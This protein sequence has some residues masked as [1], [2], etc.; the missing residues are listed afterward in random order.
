MIPEL[1][2]TTHFSFLR[3]ASSPEELFAAAAAQVAGVTGRLEVPVELVSPDLVPG[4]AEIGARQAL[5]GEFLFRFGGLLDRTL[6]QSDF[7]LGYLSVLAWLRLDRLAAYGV[8]PEAAQRALRCVEKAYTP[9]D[10]WRRAGS[11]TAASLSWRSRLRLVHLAFNAG[12]VA[13]RGHRS[14]SADP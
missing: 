10:M 5:A 9:S 2:V 12:L 7:D 6:R 3:G 14:A 1:Q 13:A 11:S 4:V 8:P